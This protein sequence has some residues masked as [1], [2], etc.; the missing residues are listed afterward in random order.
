MGDQA[1]LTRPFE[2]LLH[3]HPL[4]L[5]ERTSS[6]LVHSKSLGVYVFYI[7]GLHGADTG[8]DATIELFIV[9]FQ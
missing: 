3:H 1:G 5:Y 2:H 9:H 6:L 7:L 4:L 8:I